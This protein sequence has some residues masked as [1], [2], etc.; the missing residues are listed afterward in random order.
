MQVPAKVPRIA[1]LAGICFLLL[2]QFLSRSA[3]YERKYETW[4]EMY[5]EDHIHGL[6]RMV[7]KESRDILFRRD[8]DTE[9]LY[10]AAFTVDSSGLQMLLKRFSPV[11]RQEF[12][13]VRFPKP[14]PPGYPWGFDELSTL[15]SY[16]G[17]TAG[18][19]YYVGKC[20]SDRG[21]AVLVVNAYENKVY[22]G[23]D[24]RNN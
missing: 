8:D 16:D 12:A 1:I 18:I 10:W 9:R 19:G 11:D 5:M 24:D 20:P 3:P 13:R 23:C 15:E 4:Q 21:L 7:P 6:T 14:P 22:F 17:R 2:I